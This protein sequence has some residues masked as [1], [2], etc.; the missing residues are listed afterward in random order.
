MYAVRVF[1]VLLTDIYAGEDYCSHA[2]AGLVHELYPGCCKK[3][4]H[5]GCQSMFHLIIIL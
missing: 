5:I 2:R 3:F 1:S 4:R